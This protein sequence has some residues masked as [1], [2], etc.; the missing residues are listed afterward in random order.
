MCFHSVRYWLYFH[1]GIYVFQECICNNAYLLFFSVPP[2]LAGYSLY[3]SNLSIS[4]TDGYLCHHHEGPEL[5]SLYQDRS[6]NHLGQYVI[7]YNERN[8]SVKYPDTYYDYAILELCKVRIYGKGRYLL[9]VF[10][11]GKKRT[12]CLFR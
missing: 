2:R 1:L 3:V 8:E 4:K 9:A 12:P 7:I 11:C 5:P 6:C 10:K